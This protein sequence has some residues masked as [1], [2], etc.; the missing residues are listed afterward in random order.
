MSARGSST[1]DGGG[2]T[3]PGGLLDVLNVAS[4]VLDADG[5]ITLWSPQ[6]Q[7]LFGYSAEEAL[8]RYAAG[9]GRRG[10]RR[11]G[12]EAVRGRHGRRPELGGGVPRPAQGRHHP[13]GGVPQH[14]AHGRPGRGLRPGTG[15]RPDDGAPA[16]TRPGPVHPNGRAVPASASPCWTPTCAT[17]WSTRRWSASTACRPPSHLGRTVREVLPS[18]DAEPW[19]TRHARCCRPGEPL[20]D[21]LPGG[22][23]P[24]RPAAGARLV[25]A[26]S[27]AW[28]TRA[29]RCWASPSRSGTSPTSTRRPSRRRRRAAGS[30]WS[31]APRPASAPPWTWS[32]PPVN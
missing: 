13:A 24:G 14:A 4:V 10:A 26:P 2:P 19:R 23:H 30:P 6:A 3:G 22:T 20:V 18:L 16:G 7:E 8:G 21:Q 28:R 29:A 27:T 9:A 11:P 1:G 12:A 17:S 15:R 25:R 31:P 5:R 32:A